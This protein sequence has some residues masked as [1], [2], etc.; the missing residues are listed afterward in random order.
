MKCL[1]G[2]CLLARFAAFDVTN[3]YVAAFQPLDALHERSSTTA[4]LNTALPVDKHLLRQG[5]RLWLSGK[6]Q[7]PLHWSLVTGL[8]N[9]LLR[10][11]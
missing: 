6:G 7:P 8:D 2:G 11:P 4:A 1:S 3:R 5:A 10:S 9:A